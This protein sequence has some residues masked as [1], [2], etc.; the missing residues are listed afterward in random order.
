[1]ISILRVLFCTLASGVDIRPC[2]DRRRWPDSKMDPMEMS[3]S[4]HSFQ[5]WLFLRHARSVSVHSW[6]RRHFLYSFR[7]TAMYSV[8]KLGQ[9]V[10]SY[11]STTVALSWFL[12]LHTGVGQNS[13]Q[14]IFKERIM[15][16]ARDLKKG[17]R[18]KYCTCGHCGPPVISMWPSGQRSSPMCRTLRWIPGHSCGSFGTAPVRGLSH[19][20][21][22]QPPRSTTVWLRFGISQCQGT[23]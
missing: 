16:P 15:T 11:H 1:M 10:L 13:I 12:H 6:D 5:G 22:S 20:V 23:T 14:E 9:E 7:L 3:L 17:R 21:E 4:S 2:R 19:G 18:S 8:Q